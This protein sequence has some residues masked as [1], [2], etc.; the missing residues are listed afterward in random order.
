MQLLHC[1]FPYIHMRKILFYFLSVYSG[2]LLQYSTE[3]IWLWL[4]NGE[5]DGFPHVIP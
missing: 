3:H 4:R 5:E 2:W 1:E